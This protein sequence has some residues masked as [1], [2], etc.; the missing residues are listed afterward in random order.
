MVEK[1]E[2]LK[3]LP[4]RARGER[5]GELRVRR[6]IPNAGRGSW[7]PAIQ[8]VG[9]PFPDPPAG[10]Q[11]GPSTWAVW[12][13]HG[14]LGRGPEGGLWGYRKIYGGHLGVLGFVMDFTEYDLD[15][16]IEVY[17]GP[18]Q[19]SGDPRAVVALRTVIARGRGLTYI[20]IDREDALTDPTAALR[21]A[22]AGVSRSQYQ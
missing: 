7:Q 12:W 20:V 2:T 22:L 19:S 11:D 1:L 3:I 4:R 14:R 16:G 9:R 13:A 21:L 15:I 8:P 10:W 5:Q 6:Q 17:S 18:E